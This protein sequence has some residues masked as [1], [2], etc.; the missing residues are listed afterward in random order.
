[1]MKSPN[2]GQHCVFT[3]DNKNFLMQVSKVIET[4]LDNVDCFVD[5]KAGQMKYIIF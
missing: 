4:N 1:M 3:R 5:F 2:I